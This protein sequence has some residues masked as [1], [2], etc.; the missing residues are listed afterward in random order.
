MLLSYCVKISA[1]GYDPAEG[2]GTAGAT[3]SRSKVNLVCHCDGMQYSHTV[4]RDTF[5]NCNKCN[6]PKTN[7]AH[8]DSSLLDL[9]L[10]MFFVLP[11]RFSTGPCMINL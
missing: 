3:Q 1:P 6:T 9:E 8:T 11:S 10:R 4:K 7:C 2:N 5:F